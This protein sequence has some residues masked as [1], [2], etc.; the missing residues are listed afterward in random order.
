MLPLASLVPF[1]GTFFKDE[2]MEIIKKLIVLFFFI[3]GCLFFGYAQN[4]LLESSNLSTINIDSYSDEELLEF[5]SRIKTH[6][7]S[8]EQAYQMLKSKG[9]PDDQLIKLKDRL[10]GNFN[11]SKTQLSPKENNPQRKIDSALLSNPTQDV[12]RDFSIFG[13][14]LFSKNSLVFEPNIRIAT[15]S[16][17]IVG[18]DDELLISV[19][20][21]SEQKY[22]LTVSAEGEIYIPNVGPLFVSG[23]SIEEARKKIIRK[24]SSTIYRA[25]NSGQT[26]VSVSL[27]KIRSIRVTVIGQA[28][29]PGTYTI[30]SLTTLYNLLYL[31]GGPNDLGSL[32]NIEV[33]RDNEVKQVADIYSFLV[34]GNQKDNILLKEG[35]VVRIPYY[36]T[37]VKITGN[38]RREG[39]F[40]LQKNETFERLLEYCG[41]FN[42]VAYKASVQVISITDKNR[43]LTDLAASNFSNF[44]PGSG[45]EFFVNRLNDKL[46]NKVSISGSIVRPGNYEL[47]ERLTL[48]ELIEKAGGLEETAFTERVS[49]FRYEKNRVSSIFSYNLDSMLKEN[50]A[51]YLQKDDSVSIKSLFD[52]KETQYV[53]IEGNVRK[54]GAFA[55]RENLTLQD[56]LVF[57][58]GLGEMGD[59]AIVEISRREKNANTN[60]PNFAETETI[61][62]SVSNEGKFSKDIKL[63]AFD[64]I[65]VKNLPGFIV[66][67]SVIVLGDVKIPGKYG[68]EKSREKISDIIKRAGG[69]KISADSSSITIR[70]IIRSNLSI[71]ERKN[72]FQRLLDLDADSINANSKLNNEINKSYD[73]ISVNL[74]NALENP[75]SSENLILEDG[76]IL[77][78][79]KNTNLVKISGDVYY[80]TV[81]SLK[82]NKSVKYYVQ[83]AGNF[84][85][86]ARKSGTMV[87][88]PNGKVKSVKTFLFFKS[89]PNVTSRSEIFVPQKNKSNRAKLGVGELA[90]LVSALGIVANVILSTVK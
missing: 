70:R 47:T 62:I 10:S 83:Q 2:L 74:L 57:A 41:G 67:R 52:F 35:D 31:C 44:E 16:T 86:T 28:V 81:T 61:T 13:T 80:P 9:L 4:G 22:N 18:P 20:G 6:N 27:G 17:Y 66:Q 24:L 49:I 51:I 19:F 68:L 23:L 76:D 85:P 26:K 89:Y 82:E 78:V 84:M 32:R 79:D 73:I 56:V 43:K 1:L 50:I 34:S 63:K 5:S 29:K 25:I 65:V 48:N 8:E 39:K 60:N 54:P 58:D 77:T 12:V 3:F 45:D 15:P 7:L 69:F 30:S 55:W 14:E 87:I 75:L 88:Y 37:R 21:L 90:L 53:T 72:L 36:K 11:T 33:I 64:I 40:E 42:E 59:S 38:V 71:E 46:S